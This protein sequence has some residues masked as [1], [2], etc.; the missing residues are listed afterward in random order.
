MDKV[1]HS[2]I[3]MMK[4]RAFQDARRV[5]EKRYF[6]CHSMLISRKELCAGINFRRR[7]REEGSKVKWPY[8]GTG[9]DGRFFMPIADWINTP[10]QIKITTFFYCFLFTETLAD[11]LFTQ[12]RVESKSDNSFK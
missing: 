5:D 6:Y 8:C 9:F 1:S 10:R 7:S 12:K 11:V 2:A 3:K 4:R